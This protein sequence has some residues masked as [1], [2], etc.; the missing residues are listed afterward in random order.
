MTSEATTAAYAA[1]NTTPLYAL[2]RR[3]GAKMVGFAGYDMPVS[4]PGGII[5]EHLHTRE[6]AGIFDVSHMGQAVL[7][8]RD[9]ETVAAAL[10]TL[11]A[12]D[13]LALKPGAQRYTQLLNDQGGIID[14][15]MVARPAGSAGGRLHLVVN[16]AR[17][18]VDFLHI[19]AMIGHRVRLDPLP[20]QA[21][22]A[23][24]GPKAAQVMARHAP[25]AAGLDFMGIAEVTV[26]GIPCLISRSG[27]TGEDG[28]EISLAARHAEDLFRLLVTEPEVIPVGLG[29]RDTLR[30]EAGLCL[31]GQDIDETTSPVEA[32]LEWSIGK[33]RREQSGFPGAARIR[34]ELAEG[35]AR[36]RI[37]LKLEG[38]A[39]A[40]AGA[41][42][43]TP[44]GQEIGRITSGAFS[45]SLGQAIAMGYVPPDYAAP[46][47]QLRVE[48]RGSA[49]EA[50]V[51]KMPFVAH[52]YVRHKS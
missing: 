23:L 45:P 26:H 48:I 15:L 7:S 34:R 2:H 28:F 40:R 33:R 49:V 31:Y 5:K 20:E 14:D 17:K 6:Q 30:L 9:H 50:R 16:A 8:G 43:M 12:A 3:L 21:L 52:R 19:E 24:Q 4:Y 18:T 22:L 39:A 35:P 1:L 29:A 27:Y 42:V 37:G 47:M 51:T 36:R 10:E 38:R 46:G 11:V 13:I 41:V 44:E 25:A 32:G